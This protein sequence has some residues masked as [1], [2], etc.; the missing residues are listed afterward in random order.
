MKK[1]CMI[2]LLTLIFTLGLPLSISAS[3]TYSVDVSGYTDVT[4]TIT[5]SPA[6]TAGSYYIKCYSPGGLF[7]TKTVSKDPS[8]V[9]TVSVPVRPCRSQVN[10]YVVYSNGQEIGAD[11]TWVPYANVD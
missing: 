5:S 9:T 7:T 10:W 4:C 1:K 8:G 2:L 11:G 6:D 3:S